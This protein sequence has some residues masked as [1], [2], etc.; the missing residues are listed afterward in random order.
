MIVLVGLILFVSIGVFIIYSSTY[1]EEFNYVAL[2][3]SLAAGRNSYGGYDYGYADYV[4]D[5]LEQKDKLSSYANYAV[6]GY[7]TDNVINDIN[8]NRIIEVEGKDI[9]LKRALR[10]SDLVT[11]SI[12]V[13][14]IL[15]NVNISSIASLLSDRSNTIRMVDKTFEKIKDVLSSVRQYAKGDI[16]VIGYYNPFP[17]LTEYKKNIDYIVD[18]SDKQ[19]Q[20]ICNA[21][22]THYATISNVIGK[23]SDY[24]P[25]PLDIHPNIQGYK[26]ISNT[27][28]K[29]I[30]KEMLK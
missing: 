13:N 6:S 2:G 19:Y 22:E 21:N 1:K 17:G 7:S 26:A 4:R 28:I 16:I 18:Y 9:G 30:D 25:N 8:H 29:I 3:D 10:E 11:I 5:Y 12:G 14:D 23:N 27:I 15:K 24:L 20:K